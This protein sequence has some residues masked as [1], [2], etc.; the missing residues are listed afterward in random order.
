MNSCLMSGAKLVI[1]EKYETKEMFNLI[2]SENISHFFAV[3]FI[4]KKIIKPK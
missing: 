4:F 2:E 3:P 1:M